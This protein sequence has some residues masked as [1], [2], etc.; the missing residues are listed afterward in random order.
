MTAKLESYVPAAPPQA[1]ATPA[2]AAP[3]LPTRS[4]A[5]GPPRRSTRRC[6]PR[7]K[8][9][10]EAGGADEWVRAA[11]R[12]Q[13]RGAPSDGRLRA[14]SSEKEKT[15]WKEKKK[16]EAT[17]RRALRAPGLARRGRPRTS[18]TWARACTGTSRTRRRTSST[19]RTARSARRRTACRRWTRRRRWRRRWGCTRVQAALVRLPPRGGHGHALPQLADSQARRRPAHDHGA[20]AGAEGGAALGAGE[21]GGAAAGAR[22]GARLHARGAPSS[23]TRWRT[24]A[25][26]WW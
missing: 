14:S 10:E 11:A 4:P 13:G 6:S 20:E 25:R 8:A 15:A 26:T 22:R 5:R 2:A 17:E 7:W 23:P 16:A 1:V 12:L 24:R 9:I 19:S 18:A 21:R 3:R